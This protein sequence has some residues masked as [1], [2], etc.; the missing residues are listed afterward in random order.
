MAKNGK[1]FK[2]LNIFW[3]T[4]DMK[5][6]PD[7]VIMPTIP[8]IPTTTPILKPKIKRPKKVNKTIM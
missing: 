3:G 1:R 7:M 8:L 6:K 2:P 5:S 4:T